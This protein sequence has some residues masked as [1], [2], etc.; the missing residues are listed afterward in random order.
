MA[1]SPQ[2]LLRYIDHYTNLGVDGIFIYQADQF[3]AN[4]FLNKVF[5]PV[6]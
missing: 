4:P 5:A 2:D 6:E 3:T 1:H